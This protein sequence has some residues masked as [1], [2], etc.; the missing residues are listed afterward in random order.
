MTAE[1]QIEAFKSYASEETARKAVAK[2]GFDKYRHFMHTI[3]EPGR[4]Q[5]R[6]VPVFVGRAAVD[7][8]VHF[9]FNVVA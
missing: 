7:A 9:D 3:T 1:F 4:H 2:A 6:I 5:G 8:G